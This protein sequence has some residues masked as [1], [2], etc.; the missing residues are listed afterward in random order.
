MKI[1]YDL[2]VVGAGSG[3][4]GAALTGA[5]L[6]L[7]VLLVERSDTIGGTVSVARSV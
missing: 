2:A 1:H 7:S 4:I 6:G 5:R 3:G